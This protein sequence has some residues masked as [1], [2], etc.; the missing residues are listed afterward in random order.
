[1]HANCLTPKWAKPLAV[2]FLISPG[3]IFFK[4]QQA[5]LIHPCTGI[6]YA[7]ISRQ[8][9]KAVACGIFQSYDAIRCSSDLRR[10]VYHNRSAV[11]I[12]FNTFGLSEYKLK[13]I[14]VQH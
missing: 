14:L 12:D 13:V 7:L 3:D 5:S 11:F 1:M 2:I 8:L 10:F 6:E 9:M 4:T